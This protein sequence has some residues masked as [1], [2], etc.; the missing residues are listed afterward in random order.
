MIMAKRF[1]Q[2]VGSLNA[3]QQVVIGV[4]YDKEKEKRENAYLDSVHDYYV[5]LFC[6]SIRNNNI[7]YGI[8]IL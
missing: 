8:N 5:R 2:L 7:L 1:R 6:T 4:I 3:S